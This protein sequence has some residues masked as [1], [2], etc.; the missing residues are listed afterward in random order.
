MGSYFSS[1]QEN[2]PAIV[3]ITP[4]VEETKSVE[5][6]FFENDLTYADMVSD[7]FT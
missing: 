5:D 1:Q 7:F 4:I 2:T 3:S 6:K